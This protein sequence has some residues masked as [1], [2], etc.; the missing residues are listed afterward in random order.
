MYVIHKW[1]LTG[2]ETV[3]QMPWQAHVLDAILQDDEI[4]VYILADTTLVKSP[5]R[6]LCL[7]TGNAFNDPPGAF[8]RT[9][10]TTNGIVWHVFYRNER[11][12][13]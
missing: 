3:I 11:V 5:W 6:F 2:P 8:I 10:Q 1:P 13:L 12:L 9:L 7:N 4:V